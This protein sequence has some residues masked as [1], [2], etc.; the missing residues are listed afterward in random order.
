MMSMPD[1][2]ASSVSIKLISPRPPP[3]SSLKS[4]LKFLLIFSK[5]SRKRS[6]ER[7]L[8]SAQRFFSRGNS[9]GDIVPLRG[10]KKRAAQSDSESSS[11]AIMFDGAKVLQPLAQLFPRVPAPIC[12]SN[13]SP[14]T[15][16]RASSSRL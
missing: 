13:S 10:Q 16:S 4:S 15:T 11:S 9:F 8:I 14:M 1:S 7:R 12:K 3:N 5:A 6:R 2:S